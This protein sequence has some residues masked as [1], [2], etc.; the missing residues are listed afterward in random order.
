MSFGNIIANIEYAQN[1]GETKLQDGRNLSQVEK[2]LIRETDKAA[3][4]HEKAEQPEKPVLPAAKLNV[5]VKFAQAGSSM[6]E[7][8]MARKILE[9]ADPRKILD[10]LKQV[11]EAEGRKP[12]GP[13]VTPIPG[14]EGS[15][16]SGRGM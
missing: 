6:E 3:K 2:D 11:K 10:A 9:T 15:K 13:I 7:A 1:C 5:V 4:I 16:G 8:E 12:I 14:R